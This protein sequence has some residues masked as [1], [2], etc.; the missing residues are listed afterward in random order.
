[1]RMTT[2]SRALLVTPALV[3]ACGTSSA[4][5][6]P[7]DHIGS[8]DVQIIP[9][10]ELAATHR[11]NVYLQEGEVG[12]GSPVSGGTALSLSP[13]LGIR[14]KNSDLVFSFDF[15]YEARKYLQSSVSNLDRF[16]NFDLGAGLQL[17]P[18]GKVGLRVNDRF[19]ITGH[20]AEDEGGVSE[21][22]YQQHLLNDLG[23]FVTVR[24]GGP[25]E[26]DV[27]G[28]VQVDQWNVP[29][30]FKSQ[31]TD[32]G[33]DLDLQSGLSGPALNSRLGYGPALEGKWRFFPK[34]AVVADFQYQWFNWSDNIVDA[35][36]DG[37]SAEEIGDFL[38]I[39][40]GSQW[41]ARAGLRG[42]VTPKLV[43]G[44]L[45]G[46]GQA[47][48]DEESV[49]AQADELGV[50]GSAEF[51]DSVGFGVDL[52]NFPAG[53]LAEVEAEY[54]FV[55]DQAIIL[56]YRRDFQDVYFTN[57][58]GYDRAMLTYKGL[59]A[60]R[61]G[62]E[63]SGTYRYERYLGEVSRD[64]HVIK[65]DLG[66]EYRIQDYLSARLGVGWIERASADGSHPEIEYDDVRFEG[67][68]RF[69]Y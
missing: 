57:Y 46:F 52:K 24:P 10:V 22:A 5:A 69:T 13:S 21:S 34:T 18:D 63:A 15:L 62:L 32:R 19:S 29:E 4:L 45:A 65:A 59:F 8:E 16:N 17:F 28:K 67:A 12:G 23:A 37:I 20:E 38:A 1:M 27:G 42:R 2:T 47:L 30:E 36:G 68:V 56:G 64:D 33:T 39:P 44:A 55:E 35:Q 7:G 58:V 49:T 41:R 66:G 26:L 31:A 54:E 50:A 48:Y 60:E 43:V 25:L 14:A 61:F 51:A 6:A 3:L 9:A 53:L 11:T 40:D